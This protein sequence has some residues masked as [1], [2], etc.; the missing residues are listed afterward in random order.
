MSDLLKSE[1]AEPEAKAEPTPAEEIP[2]GE[3]PLADKAEAG[4]ETEV[5]ADGGQEELE[6]KAEEKAKAEGEDEPQLP[7]EMKSALEAWEE[8][9]GPLPAALQA[10]VGKRIGKLTAAREA[11]KLRADKAETELARV[12]AEAESLRNDPNRPVHT[13][14]SNVMD[15]K[16]VASLEAT[17][18]KM[19]TEIE[20]FLDGVATDEERGR[21]ERFM[22]SRQLDERGLKRELRTMN[23]FM[24]QDLPKLKEQARTFQA[25]EAANEP[26][27]KQTF[28]WLD[29]KAAPEFAKAQA[30][31]ALM[32]ELRSR[33]PA[34]RVATGTYVVGL[35]VMDAL[36]AAGY[37]GD[38]LKAVKEVLAKAYPA[39]G[40]A[41][42]TAKTP[43]PKA[44]TAG[45]APQKV[46]PQ[47][48]DAARQKFSQ[49]PTRQ[50]AVDMARAALAGV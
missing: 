20:N 45:A 17:S 10:V 3:T 29:D 25:Q 9:G 6:P 21:I 36:H 44:P 30:V 4:A 27:V 22:Q 16:T 24:T 47:K 1:F 43:P 13:P 14:A 15:G 38:A 23:G 46:T 11:E 19:V 32:P 5:L 39:K 35:T 8:T 26:V 34:H 31:Q 37:T 28:P 12:A 49:A 18:Q 48:S 42:A 40:T 41:T 33:T 50:N 2:A 7:A